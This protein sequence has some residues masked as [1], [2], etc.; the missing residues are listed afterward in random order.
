M[1]TAASGWLGRSEVRHRVVELL[2]K[3][4][5]PHSAE[6]YPPAYRPGRRCAMPRLNG[7]V[8]QL[9]ELASDIP[10]YQT[11]IERKIE[12]VRGLMVG[13]LS[14]LISKTPMAKA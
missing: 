11:T 8:T 5:D 3:K 9:A 10:H 14:E 13:R 2:R 12:A 7:G 1:A 6:N 4:Q